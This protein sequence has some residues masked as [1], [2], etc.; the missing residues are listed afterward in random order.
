[1]V[2]L[3]SLLVFN[4]QQSFYSD[5]ITKSIN[6]KYNF[7]QQDYF[8]PLDGGGTRL[9]IY[10]KNKFWFDKNVCKIELEGVHGIFKAKIDKERTENFNKVVLTLNN[11]IQLDTILDFNQ[12]HKFRHLQY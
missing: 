7:T 6:Q 4:V 2:L 12:H 9:L 8:Y 10:E 1:M 3:P 11:E 5:R